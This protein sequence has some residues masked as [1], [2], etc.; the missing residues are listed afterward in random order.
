MIRIARATLPDQLKVRLNSLAK[1]VSSTSEQRRAAEARAIWNKTSTRTNVRTPLTEILRQMA[2]GREHCM[3]CGDNQGTGIDHYEPI[4]RNP[5]RTFDWLNHLLACSVCNS[6]QKRDQFPLD[7]NDKPLLIDPTSEDPF[8]HL[9]L[10]LSLGYYE[11]TSDKGRATIKVCDLN[12]PIL[13]RGRVQARRVVELCLEQWLAASN[14]GDAAI[15]DQ[16]V[17]TVQEQPFAD[18]CQSMLRQSEA[19]GAEIVFADRPEIL[20]ILRIAELGAALLA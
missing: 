20:N 18:V 4:V 11:A 15:M 12:R 19:A 2:P 6:H 8:E 17:L 10:T 16:A 13:L 3:Y 9:L 7:E 14:V 5:L 1:E